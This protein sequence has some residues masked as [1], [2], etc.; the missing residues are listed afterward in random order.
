MG[1]SSNVATKSKD[2]FASFFSKPVVKAA[3]KSSGTKS[4]I[5]DE[6]YTTSFELKK[7]PNKGDTITIEYTLLGEY[8]FQYT[9][10]DSDNPEGRIVKDALCL[11]RAPEFKGSPM[12]AFGNKSG[13]RL[14]R[15]GRNRFLNLVL[16]LGSEQAEALR[17]AARQPR[18]IESA[19]DEEDDS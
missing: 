5:G 19:G 16:A 8:P 17:K 9:V 2:P 10:K 7:G 12:V 15:Q 4:K 1:Q 11:Y 18:V 3:G 13:F 6:T 14:S